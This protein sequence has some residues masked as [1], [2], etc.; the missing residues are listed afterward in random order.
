MKGTR[1]FKDMLEVGS[2]IADL[3]EQGLVIL[4]H[5]IDM[6]LAEAFDYLGPPEGYDRALFGYMMGLETIVSRV[7]FDYYDQG[8][9]LNNTE[10]R[11]L[12]LY[13]QCRQT[14]RYQ[15]ALLRE[16]NGE[17]WMFETPWSEE[18]S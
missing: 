8:A 1:Y 16:R 4:S 7:V 11:T 15:E 13:N 2:M 10:V 6:V 5:E 12:V 3:K 18:A 14:Q 9:N 17:P